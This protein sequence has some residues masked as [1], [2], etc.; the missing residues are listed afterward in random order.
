M[1]NI[2]HNGDSDAMDF[3]TGGKQVAFDNGLPDPGFLPPGQGQ[4]DQNLKG[5]GQVDPN[6]SRHMSTG[7]IL[8]YQEEYGESHFSGQ[9]EYMGP[10]GEDNHVNCEGQGHNQYI[11]YSD[12]SVPQIDADDQSSSNYNDEY[13]END[14][15][16]SDEYSD[17]VQGQGYNIEEPFDG[18]VA[19]DTDHLDPEW[20]PDMSNDRQRRSMSPERS[21]S[22]QVETPNRQMSPERRRRSESPE[23]S[24]SPLPGEQDTENMSSPSEFSQSTDPAPRPDLVSQGSQQ[25]SETDSLDSRSEAEGSPRKSKM[26]KPRK[27][28]VPLELPPW[29]DNVVIPPPPRMKPTMIGKNA[30]L[31]PPESPSRLRPRTAPARTHKG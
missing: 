25:W 14:Y 21:V 11:P 13:V 3:M 27:L 15:V 17:N 18:A 1:E 16:P 30:D 31:P 7:E 2:Q 10:D 29:N 12:Q 5:Q 24:V 9:H 20:H 28:K 6:M 23:R 26:P 8:G 22:P 19:M 4:M